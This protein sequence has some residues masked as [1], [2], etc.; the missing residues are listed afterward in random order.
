MNWDL[1][2]QDIANLGARNSGFPRSA[3]LTFLKLVFDRSEK[4]RLRRLCPY[5]FHSAWKARKM[6]S[7]NHHIFDPASMVSASDI[8]PLTACRL[9]HF[10][11]SISNSRSSLHSTVFI[12][13][14]SWGTRCLFPT[15][16]GQNV[17]SSY[18]IFRSSH[19]WAFSS[20]NESQCQSSAGRYGIVMWFTF[21]GV[22][23]PKLSI[24]A[25]LGG[26]C[27]RCIDHV[28]FTIRS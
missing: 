1:H 3:K 16:N 17:A 4:K 22:W 28:Y 25:H 10:Y 20:S 19:Y 9:A 26:L 27:V 15:C 13:S 21:I 2:Q 7:W 6:V 18:A 23:L 11:P 5:R 12:N 24:A 14:T 8:R